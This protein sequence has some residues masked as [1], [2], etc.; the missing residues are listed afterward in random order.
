MADNKSNIFDKLAEEVDKIGQIGKKITGQKTKKSPPGTAADDDSLMG[1]FLA[2]GALDIPQAGDTLE[3]K[4]IE[5]TPNS[6]LLDLGPL[7]TGI[8]MGKEIKDGMAGSV[9]LKKNDIV[10]ATL[11]DLENE[12]GYIELSIREASYGKSWTLEKLS[13]PKS[14]MLIGED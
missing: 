3:G 12:D 10:S 9:R 1:K 8:V 11:V 4:V 6:I 7:G 2:S 5:T 13:R 14:L